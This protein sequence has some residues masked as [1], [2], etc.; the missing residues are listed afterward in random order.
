MIINLL[1]QPLLHFLLIGAVFFLIFHF[2]SLNRDL[3]SDLKTVIVNKNSL[4]NFMQYRSKRFNRE[5]FEAKLASISDEELNKLID[6]Y[7]REEVLYREA[8]GLGMDKDDYV[9]KRRMVQKI[10]FINEDLVNYSLKITDEDV[11]NY[12]I[13]NIDSYKIEP[14]ATFTHVYFGKDKNGDAEAKT[15]A[16]EE[17]EILK[18]NQVRWGVGILKE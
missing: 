11:K 10:E 12:Y 17:L 8:L 15:L 4:V 2:T 16:V 3:E 7:V 13:E 14:N 18:K 9:I 6:E 1:K 5:E